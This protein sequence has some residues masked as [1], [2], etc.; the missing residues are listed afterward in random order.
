MTNLEKYN[1]IFIDAF[2]ADP[3]KLEELRYR[4]TEKW[5]SMAHMDLV[6]DLEEKFNIRFSTFDILNFTTYKKGLEIM[7]GYGVDFSK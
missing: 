7:T 1:K 2:G 5:D 4:K 3:D 6:S